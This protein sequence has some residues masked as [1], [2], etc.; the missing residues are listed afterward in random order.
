MHGSVPLSRFI[1]GVLQP[2]SSRIPHLTIHI[3]RRQTRPA[4]QYYSKW[5]LPRNHCQRR[6]QHAAAAVG[7]MPFNS[8]DQPT[9][10]DEHNESPSSSR[11]E[12]QVT[13]NTDAASSSRQAVKESVSM[14]DLLQENNPDRILL[15][16][17]TSSIG[18]VFVAKADDATFAQAICALDPDYFIVPYRNL[19]RFV[20]PT[21]ESE[22]RF[23]MMKSLEERIET[24]IHILD[25]LVTFRQERGH[26]ISLA[27]YRH[28]LR[29]A[30]AGG[31]GNL[32]RNVFRGLMPE[33]N[34]TPDVECY[35]YFMEALNWNQAYGRFERYKLRVVAH[36]MELRS[37]D[38][39]RTGFKGHGVASPT[40][41]DNEQS[42]RLEVL[43]VFNELVRQGLKGNE[44]TFCN[45]M[46]AMARE[47]DVASV[48]SVLKSV[49][50]IDVDALERYDEEELESPTFYEPDSPLRPTER[51]LFTV[52]HAFGTNN[53]VSLAGMLLDYVSR[54]YNMTI[55]ES[56]WTH[57]L[58]WTFVLGCQEQNWRVDNGF[59]VG[60]VPRRAVESLYALFH[61]E[62]FN[63]KPSIVD[64]IYR[65]KM[66]TRRRMLDETLED[67]RECMRM[68]DEDRTNVSV[69]YDRMRDHLNTKHDQ[70]FE[71]GVA[72][73]DFLDLK[74]EYV[75]ASL[76]LD[77]HLQLVSIAVRNALKEKDWPLGRFGVEWSYRRLPQLIEEWQAYLPNLVPYYTPTGHVMLWGHEHRKGAIVSANS[78]QTT[79]VG[80]MRAMFDTYSPA[81]LRHSA[82]Y[83]H[84]GPKGLAAFDEEA[85]SDDEPSRSDW[86]LKTEDQRRQERLKKRRYG[87]LNLPGGDWRIDEWKPWSKG[88]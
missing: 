3:L 75:F 51:L 18:D 49:W 26:P 66:R 30:A 10:F 24:F 47:G 46:I 53:Q 14:E 7:S 13:T 77:T 23:R 38:R 19:Y 87:P 4:A 20:K 61:N 71:D 25:A 42:I 39:R 21:L 59:G 56:V 33:N 36:Y 43:R 55:P 63:V 35:N 88:P 57:L 1:N 76:R 60:R 50:N 17:V 79:K 65:V 29:C 86:V 78:A 15:G 70:M 34:I 54:N 40:N 45:L 73:P 48:K 5:P 82:D 2:S 11:T 8:F 32:A 84:R 72:S 83:V 31:H 41:P 9:F 80:S 44:A 16:F 62:P 69:L 58:E 37:G 22:P 85:A 6:F 64:L 81:R 27:V 68:L 52:V 67:I 28:L 74:R 12:S